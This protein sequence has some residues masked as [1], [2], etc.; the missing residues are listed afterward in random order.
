[1]RVFKGSAIVDAEPALGNE[2]RAG[3]R[4]VV[5]DVGTG[6]GRWPYELARRDSESFYVGL[7]PDADALREYAYRA[8]RKPSRGGVDN[9][10]YVVA[11]VER[12]PAELEAVADLV[13]VSFPWGALLRGLLRPEP[14]LLAALV[15]VA[16]PG[17]S[18][19]VVLTYDP[20]HDHGATPDGEPL[21]APALAYIKETLAPAY[22]SAGLEVEEATLLSR[23]EALSIP[24][25]WGRRLLHGREREVYLVR[26]RR[27]K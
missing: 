4:P 5:V 23:E 18:V 8:S 9:V 2:L 19:D 24:S 3:H 10:L 1:M 26:A 6:D 22:E 7:D 15:S 21:P 27:A 20:T 11:S 13:R 25:T 14:A 12:L 16:K 17:A